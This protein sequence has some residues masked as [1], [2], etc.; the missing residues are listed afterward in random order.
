MSGP[1]KASGEAIESKAQLVEDLAHGCKPPREWR[2][3]TEHE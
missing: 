3:G 2:I 1:P